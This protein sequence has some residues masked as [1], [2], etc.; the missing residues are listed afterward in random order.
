M[1]DFETDRR[2]RQSPRLQRNSTVQSRIHSCSRSVSAEARS[3]GESGP[4]SF[5]VSTSGYT[6][7]ATAGSRSCRAAGGRPPS[8]RPV[9][10]R[11]R[12]HTSAAAVWGIIQSAASGPDVTAPGR[13]PKRP[14]RQ[15]ESTATPVTT[16]RKPRQMTGS[17]R[18]AWRG[19]CSTSAPSF[20]SP[21]R[22]STRGGR[23]S[24]ALRPLSRVQQLIAR[25]SGHRGRRALN[26]ALLDYRAPAFTR[27]ELERTFLDL[28]RTA[29]LPRPATNVFL[30]GFEV[31]VAWPERRLVVELDG[32]EFHR[33]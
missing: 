15:R 29:E 5:I 22:E 2:A 17:Q 9:R 31:D 33:T 8:S 6:P 25:S 13:T 14:R 12:A 28:C 20:P 27:S 26:A 21:A 16:S 4:L 7:M 30:A 32:H 10:E 23:A 18:R 3:K 11:C 1:C 24:R 19:R